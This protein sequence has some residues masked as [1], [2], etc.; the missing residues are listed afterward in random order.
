[1]ILFL[2]MLSSTLKQPIKQAEVKDEKVSCCKSCLNKSNTL[3]FKMVV[4]QLILAFCYTIA[5]FMTEIFMEH[6]ELDEQTF[7]F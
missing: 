5:S 4:L 7:Q 2:C 3:Y 1:M 6:N